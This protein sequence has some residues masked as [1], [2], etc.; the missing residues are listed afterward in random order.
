MLLH[1][2]LKDTNKDHDDGLKGL[3]SVMLFII[4]QVVVYDGFLITSP[5]YLENDCKTTP[6]KISKKSAY[7]L[8][9]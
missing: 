4:F 2:H 3:D 6:F 8:L 1:L 7:Y 9:I 5:C